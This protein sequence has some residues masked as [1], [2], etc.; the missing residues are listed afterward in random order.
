MKKLLIIPLVAMTLSSCILESEDTQ[1]KWVPILEE[2]P[3]DTKEYFQG[4]RGDI[5]ETIYRLGRMKTGLEDETQPW[6]VT[7]PF[8]VGIVVY[9]ERCI[10]QVDQYNFNSQQL[11]QYVFDSW[12]IDKNI[13]YEVCY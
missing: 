9:F 7:I 6:D 4:K 8:V 1:T 10:D 2:T 11:E 13:K 5:N 12:N 3:T